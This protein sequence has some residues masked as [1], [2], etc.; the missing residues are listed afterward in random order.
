MVH[1][2]AYSLLIP[3]AFFR[4]SIGPDVK[5]NRTSGKNIFDFLRRSTKPVILSHKPP[6]LN[7]RLICHGQNIKPTIIFKS[8]LKQC[9]QQLLFSKHVLDFRIMNC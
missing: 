3:L 7:F 8:C 4:F 6:D 1:F 9:S 2:P 5:W